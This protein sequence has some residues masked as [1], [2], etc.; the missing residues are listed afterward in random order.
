MVAIILP[1]ADEIDLKGIDV[2]S[3]ECVDMSK[4]CWSILTRLS[5]V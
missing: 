2:R 5:T 3:T 1:T 4:E